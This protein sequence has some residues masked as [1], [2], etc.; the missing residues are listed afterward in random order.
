MGLRTKK[1]KAHLWCKNCS[2][3]FKKK[4]LF[5]VST[6]ENENGFYLWNFHTGKYVDEQGNELPS[7]MWIL[8]PKCGDHRVHKITWVIRK[9][10]NE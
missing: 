4:L 10:V 9:N 8:C 3:S 2:K 5:G 1:W 7:A 6:I